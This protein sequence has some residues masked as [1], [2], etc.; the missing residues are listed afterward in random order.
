MSPISSVDFI[1]N[2][3]SLTHYLEDYEKFERTAAVG[4]VFVWDIV[5]TRITE[6]IKIIFLLLCCQF[7]SKYAQSDMP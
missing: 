7:L 1:E 4:K 5:I 3:H 2:E 6:Y